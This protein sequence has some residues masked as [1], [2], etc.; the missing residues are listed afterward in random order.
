MQIVELVWPRR[1]HPSICLSLKK[2]L[3]HEDCGGC[4]GWRA[5]FE[6]FSAQSCWMRFFGL[7]RFHKK[8]WILKC[9]GR[10]PNPTREGRVRQRDA[11]KKCWEQWLK[12]CLFVSV[13]TNVVCNRFPFFFIVG[14]LG[15]GEPVKTQATRTRKSR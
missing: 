4:R 6:A 2:K 14:C 15:S 5:D 10:A 11:P 1:K 3:R 7:L 13:R 12:Y 8:S 9:A